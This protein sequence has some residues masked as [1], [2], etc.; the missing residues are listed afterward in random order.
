[1]HET[2][3]QSQAS[4]IPNSTA[5]SSSP[6][7]PYGKYFLYTLI[8][9]ILITAHISVIAVLMGEFNSTM[10]R[11]LSTTASMVIHTLAALFFFTLAS[12]KTSRI[13]KSFINILSLL[14]VASFLTSILWTWD[15]INGGLVADL[16]QTYFYTFFASLWILLFLRIGENHADKPTRIVSQI[17][18]GFTSLLYVLSLPTIFVES[19][20]DLPEM[21]YRAIA[22]TAIVLA[23]T[24]VIT[25][26]FRRIYVAKHP[27]SKTIPS[28]KSGWDIIAAFIVVFVG[29]PIIF[30]L[31]A[32][33]AAYDTHNE[34]S[35]SESPESSV[36]ETESRS[37]LPND[38]D[39]STGGQT[40]VTQKDLDKYNAMAGVDCTT[41]AQYANLNRDL[42][43]ATLSSIDLDTGIM[44][45]TYDAGNTLY[46]RWK[47]NV[48]PKVV[49]KNCSPIPFTSLKSKDT[50]SVYDGRTDDIYQ[51]AQDIRLVQKL[52]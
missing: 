41:M 15:L 43:K 18:I 1:M 32:T 34:Y 10:G 5:D 22:A 47:N 46:G 50:V 40:Q 12:K 19:L 42:S 6:K 52:N 33:L 13:V 36:R 7:T 48:L 20:N 38:E 29:L 23:T 35:E 28:V 37:E 3:L 31:T 25:T 51:D 2:P 4:Q 44:Y 21:L 14:T 24:S 49:D 30:M 16:Y 26:V 45:I 27:E 39:I 11:A 9:G 8:G 17:V